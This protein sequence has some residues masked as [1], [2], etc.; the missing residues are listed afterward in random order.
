MPIIESKPGDIETGHVEKQ[1]V[2]IIK[3]GSNQC[4]SNRNNHVISKRASDM[5]KRSEMEMTGFAHCG[6]VSI[7]TYHFNKAKVLTTASET[8]SVL[9]GLSLHCSSK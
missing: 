7:Y 3:A 2:A 1:G 8:K 5:L 6:D 4:N 9:D